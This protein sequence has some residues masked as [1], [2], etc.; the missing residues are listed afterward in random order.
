[1]SEPPAVSVVIP[2]RNEGAHIDAALRSVLEQDYPNLIEVIVADGMSTDGTREQVARAAAA[3]PRVRLVDNPT[4]ATPAAL[5]IAIGVANGEVIVR[6][7]GHVELPPGYVARA[8]AALRETGADNVGGMQLATGRTPMQRAV[9]LAMSIPMGV[10]DARFHLGGPA[11]P[12]D[13]VFLGVFRRDVFDRVGLFDEDLLRNQD[14]ELNH[15]IRAAGGTVWFVPEL[16]V[17][18]HP[19]SS[20]RALWKQYFGSGAWKR[21][22]FRKRPGAIRWRQLAP[23]AL[24]LGLVASVGLALAGATPAALVLPAV[25]A[26]ALVLTAAVTALTRRRAEALLLP[27][28]L[29]V[30]HLGWGL[31]FFIGRAGRPKAARVADAG[32]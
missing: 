3:D 32:K 17:T 22:T 24:V 18:Y 1:M 12:V 8:V 21:E 26:A 11:G 28:V 31:G 6:C 16:R 25:Y 10:G 30:M 29:P 2:A 9:A 20:L 27:V 7:D 4:G 14:S 13:T 5:N 23:P 19:R 15:R